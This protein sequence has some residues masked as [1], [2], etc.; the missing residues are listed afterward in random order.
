MHLQSP[1]VRAE[2]R[3]PRPRFPALLHRRCIIII[4]W[5]MFNS[6]KCVVRGISVSS[7][8][9]W[10]S[11]PGPGRGHIAERQW[12]V[13]ATALLW[14]QWL[15]FTKSIFSCRWGEWTT[16]ISLVV[17]ASWTNQRWRF[18]S[19]S[20]VIT[21]MWT[22]VENLFNEHHQLHVSKNLWSLFGN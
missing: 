20:V 22:S 11:S 15:I 19:I 21:T 9:R 6:R 8:V 10:R 4:E 16:S 2:G 5:Y 17:S 13:T 1:R 14:R 12:G 18:C 7:D 3:R